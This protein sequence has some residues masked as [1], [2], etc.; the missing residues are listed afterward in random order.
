MCTGHS[1]NSS[2]PASTTLAEDAA[3]EAARGIRRGDFLKLGVAGIAGASMGLTFSGST[4]GATQA[5]AQGGPGE[6][7]SVTRDFQ[8]AATEY[9]LP[10]G[11]LMAVG[12]VNTRWEMPPPAAS[13]YERG[14]VHGWGGYGVMHLVKNPSDDT[15]GRAATLTGLSEKELKTDRKANIRGGAALLAESFGG[16][17]GKKALDADQDRLEQSLLGDAESWFGA[18]SGRGMAGALGAGD[19]ISAPSGVGGGE[20]Y[21]GQ[22]FKALKKGAS[23]EV[24]AGERVSLQARDGLDLGSLQDRLQESGVQVGGRS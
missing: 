6:R 24:G 18:V 21:A 7:G 16:S 1:K 9:G 19:P 3:G 4:F 11:L 2:L 20:L 8:E 17:G 15:L 12:Y 23:R 22:V 14:N 5:G 10:V 13:E